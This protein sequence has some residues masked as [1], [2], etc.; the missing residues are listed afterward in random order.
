M[1]MMNRK[2]RLALSILYG[3]AEIFALLLLIIGG[4]AVVTG[5]AVRLAG[6]SENIGLITIVAPAIAEVFLLWIASCQIKLLQTASSKWAKLGNP[7]VFGLV[8]GFAGGEL[9]LE[10]M[11]KLKVFS[12]HID[13]INS[14]KTIFVWVNNSWQPIAGVVPA[15]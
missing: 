9:V 14:L 15:F 6:Q 4:A 13:Q 3:F 8:S 1:T 2:A 11:G 12:A 10:E 7:W 5:Y